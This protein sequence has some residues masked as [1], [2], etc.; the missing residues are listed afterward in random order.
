MPRESL[1][2][3]KFKLFYRSI[4]KY[5]VGFNPEHQHDGLISFSVNRRGGRV[6]TINRAKV[7]D[8]SFFYI[9]HDRDLPN[10]QY[11]NRR[12]ITNFGLLEGFDPSDK[13]WSS[14]LS[15]AK[16]VK[17]GIY[18]G[19]EFL[20]SVVPSL[21]KFLLSNIK[22]EVSTTENMQD[23]L[24]V[25]EGVTIGSTTTELSN[26][27]RL[28]EST[29]EGV[30]EIKEDSEYADVES[31]P[32]KQ[33]EPYFASNET[34][35]EISDI[36]EEIKRS[37]SSNGITPENIEYIKNMTTK[38]H[39]F[40][41]NGV[42]ERPISNGTDVE[43]PKL[44]EIPGQSGAGISAVGVA[45]GALGLLGAA[46]GFGYWLWNRKNREGSRNVEEAG[47]K[48][49]AEDSLPEEQGSLLDEVNV[50]SGVY[51][52]FRRNVD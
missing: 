2:K 32:L 34:S 43:G 44:A 36:I 8:I 46:M 47:V 13:V 27:S 24:P 48:D 14:I 39:V 4:V 31:A 9:E 29:T 19:K 18:G 10:V 11:N 17:P 5:G 12:I 22:T 38:D 51:Q 21:G 1:Q 40:P 15:E 50:E 41:D 30:N 3:N 42:S 28:E 37:N 23:S 52:S 33:Q 16:K 49:G 45:V 6:I 20:N 25:T 7:S 35:E 26:S